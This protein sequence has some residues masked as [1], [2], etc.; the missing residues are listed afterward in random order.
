MPARY[1]V[2][3]SLF[4]PTPNTCACSALRASSTNC[5][6]TFRKRCVLK[7]NG[8]R[9]H[10]IYLQA[11]G[12]NNKDLFVCNCSLLQPDHPS[13]KVRRLPKTWQ[14]VP[15]S[16]SSHFL[17]CAESTVKAVASNVVH[18]ALIC[19]RTAISTLCIEQRSWYDGESNIFRTGDAIYAAVVVARSTDRW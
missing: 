9:R 6:P 3:V 4:V 5:F 12:G 13:D 8:A 18:Q 19:V 1:C 16:R 17:Q 14:V 10:R 11:C 7:S 2:S 15:F